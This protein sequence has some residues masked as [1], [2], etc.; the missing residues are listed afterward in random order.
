VNWHSPDPALRGKVLAPFLG[1]AY[2]EE[3]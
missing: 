1:A 2:G 3:L